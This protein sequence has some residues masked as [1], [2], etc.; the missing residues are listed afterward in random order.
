M[1]FI[2]CV[3]YKRKFDVETEQ[4]IVLNVKYYYSLKIR[5]TLN[6]F[7]VQGKRKLANFN[8]VHIF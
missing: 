3:N 1:Y 2:Y 7:Y 8:V 4:K 5:S 6:F